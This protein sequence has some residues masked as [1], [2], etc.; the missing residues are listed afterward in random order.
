[1]QGKA[2]AGDVLLRNT[3]CNCRDRAQ[4]CLTGEERAEPVIGDIEQLVL[5]AADDGHGRGVRGGDD[6]LKLL[7]GE[8][9]GRGE[10]SLGVAVLARLG[11]GHVH[12]LG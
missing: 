3:R 7:A 9:V 1:M 4:S 10:V 2:H 8:D 12:H 5:V 11:G 6:V